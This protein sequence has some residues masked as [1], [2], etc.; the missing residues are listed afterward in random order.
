MLKTILFAVPHILR[1]TAKKYPAFREEMRRHNCTVQIKLKDGSIG[2]YYTFT[3]GQVRSEAC[4]HPK[5]D[6]T[7]MFRDLATALIF[8][9]PPMD[10][11]EVVHAA[12]QLRVIV[13]GRD[14]LVVWFMQLM[15]RIETSGLQA[16]MAMKD[17]SIRYTTNTNGGPL[18]VYVKDGRILRTTPIDFDASD[19][20]SWSISARGKRFTP[21]RRATVSPYSLA[22]KSQVY[23]DK[24][25]LYPMKRVDF[26]PNGD[27]NPQNRGISG[28]ERISW[29]EALDIV[30]NEIKRNKKE[31]G[32]GSI[33]IQHHSHHQWGNVGYYLGALLRFGNLI[34]FTRVHHN[35]DSWEG[36]YW[37]AMHH[38]GNSLRL[39]LP[40]GYGT[41]EDCLKEAEMVVFWSSD[42][43]VTSGVY[44]AFEGTER[45]LWAKSL[46]M[47]FVHIDPHCNTTAQ[48]LGGK[49]IPIR[50]GTDPALAIAI[51]YVW[52]KEGLYDK[53]YVEKR[54]TGFDQWSDYLLGERDER[55]RSRRA[56]TGSCLGQQKDL[57]CRRRHG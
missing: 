13:T 33:A 11:A 6:V 35:P 28:Y 44:S 2:R 24:R 57:P 12:K 43:E 34:G 21:R 27:R 25:I 52:L 9:K 15:N 29:D 3:G 18:F 54:T 55:T 47:K 46:G 30:S 40:G 39:G 56:C 32:P 7:M 19:A 51:M 38:F 42:P 14:E 8:L 5:P 48:L 1:R 37:G 26:D 4:I 16:G 41:V 10:R 45:R 20:P 23:S 22:L 17:G 53:E 31:H 36:W 49:W 50:P